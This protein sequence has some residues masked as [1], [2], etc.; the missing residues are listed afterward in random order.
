MTRTALY[1]F[2]NADDLLLY[3]GI[4]ENVEQRWTTHAAQKSWW[5]EVANKTVEWCAD[6][7]EALAREKRAIVA[8]CPLYNVVHVPGRHGINHRDL[9]L[10]P[11]APFYARVMAELTSRGKGKL[12]LHKTS[13]VARNTI[14]NLEKQPRPP[15]AG[16]IAAIADTLGIDR[17]EAA[18]L[19]GLPVDTLQAVATTDL[20]ALSSDQLAAESKRITDE[21]RRRA[22]D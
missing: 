11:A 7:T 13:G 4:T 6:R 20:S 15:Q 10:T 8:E 3:V 12:W 19:A 16:T 17:K 1:R 22:R 21:L 5:P 14:D 18:R 2:F 9:G